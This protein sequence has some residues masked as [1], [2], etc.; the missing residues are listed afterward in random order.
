MAYFARKLRYGAHDGEAGASYFAL[1]ELAK[2]KGGRPVY[3]VLYRRVMQFNYPEE[4]QT[5][6]IRIKAKTAEE[7]V[8]RFWPSDTE[9]TGKEFPGLRSKRWK[10]TTLW[11]DCVAAGGA[12]EGFE[13]NHD[14]R[15]IR[16]GRWA[17]VGTPSPWIKR[18]KKR[19]S[20]QFGNIGHILL[21]K[22]AQ[23]RGLEDEESN[24][25]SD[26]SCLETGYDEE[27]DCNYVPEENEVQYAHILEEIE[28]VREEI[29]FA[30]MAV[31][32]TKAEMRFKVRRT[33][34]QPIGKTPKRILIKSLRSRVSAFY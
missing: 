17:R 33:F 21:A 18:R 15:G 4:N 10:K 11:L 1:L 29:D 12:Y 25:N 9:G 6:M 22:Q 31:E 16:P 19:K 34:P 13:Y 24:L 3:F 7:A 20:L 5:E 8:N 30:R 23:L 26:L 28:K 27:N 14:H 32:V 2:K